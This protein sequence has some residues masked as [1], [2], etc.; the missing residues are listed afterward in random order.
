MK[1]VSSNSHIANPCKTRDNGLFCTV[2]REAHKAQIDSKTRAQK[3]QCSK[4]EKEI[5]ETFFG[6]NYDLQHP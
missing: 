6:L 3:W 1:I 5:R 4:T 2:G